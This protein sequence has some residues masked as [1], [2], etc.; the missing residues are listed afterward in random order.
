MLSKY[1]DKIEKYEETLKSVIR[2]ESAKAEKIFTQL[3]QLK[4]EMATKD[5]QLNKKLIEVVNLRQT[6]SS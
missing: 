1:K 5:L 6:H 3:I 4:D 2:E